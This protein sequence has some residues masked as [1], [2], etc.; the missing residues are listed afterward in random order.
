MHKI[1]RQARHAYHSALTDLSVARRKAEEHAN[2]GQEVLVHLHPCEATCAGHGHEYYGAKEQLPE[3]VEV[4][5][6]SKVL[7]WRDTE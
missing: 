7:S 1:D 4:K 6:E 3:E 5:P 2:E